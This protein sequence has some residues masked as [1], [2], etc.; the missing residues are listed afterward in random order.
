[1]STSESLPAGNR[2]VF[3]V[4]DDAD[5]REMLSQVLAL[6]GYF[7]VAA[8]NG[9]EALEHLRRGAQPCVILIDLMMPVMNGWEFRSEQVRD[10]DLAGIPLVVI[11]G[12]GGI[13][14]K[15]A[16]VGADGWLR[17]PIDLDTLLATVER[18]R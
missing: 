8:A 3:V 14:Q 9:R 13:D 11:S 5:A 6:E 2:C 7:V 12:D 1:M 17:K 18:Y 16:S 10:P 4:E 15:A